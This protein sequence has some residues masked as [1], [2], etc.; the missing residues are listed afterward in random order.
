MDTATPALMHAVFERF[1]ICQGVDLLPEGEA[2]KPFRPDDCIQ[3][4]PICDDF[5]PL[6]MCSVIKFVQQ[7]DSELEDYPSC[8]LFYSVGSSRRDLTNAIFLIGSFMILR[9]GWTSTEVNSSFEWAEPY[10]EAYRD[11]TYATSSFDLKLRDCWDSLMKGIEKGWVELPSCTEDED[12]KYGEIDIEEYEHYDNPLNGDM[13][14]VVPGKFV[15][16][17]GPR[18][19]KG[20]DF[21]DNEQSFRDFSPNFYANLLEDFNVT[22]VVR[23]NEPH[24]DGR[25]FVDRGMSFHDLEFEDCTAPPPDVVEAFLKLSDAAEGSVAVHCKAGLGR[26]GTLIGVYL[27]RREGFTA[28]EAMGWLRMMRP[29]SVIGE[30]Q[31]YLC[32]LEAAAASHGAAA[33]DDKASLSFAFSGPGGRA[34]SSELAAQVAAGAGRRATVRTS[35]GGSLQRLQTPVEGVEE[36]PLGPSLGTSA[37]LNSP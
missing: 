37:D 5:G 23:L 18:D 16:F 26:T 12:Y 24:Y 10:V 21:R 13:H 8:I 25:H 11:A 9:L 29:G 2:F 36:D 34:C 1:Y 22:D 14:E 32:A 3:Y 28:R 19:L 15:A 30:Q 27:M 31:D 35:S 6:N 7:L 33:P 17:K 4:H 20:C